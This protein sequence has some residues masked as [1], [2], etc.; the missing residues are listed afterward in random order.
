VL[1]KAKLRA[2]GI[3]MPPWDDGLRRYLAARHDAR[4]AVNTLLR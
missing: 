4:N 1:S 3:T 2:L